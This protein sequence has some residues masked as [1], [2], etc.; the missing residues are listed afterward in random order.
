[1]WLPGGSNCSLGTPEKAAFINAMRTRYEP[2]NNAASR[3]AAD[4]EKA[5]AVTAASLADAKSEYEAK[6]LWIS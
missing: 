1:M 2:F 3:A 5:A 4:R 6:A